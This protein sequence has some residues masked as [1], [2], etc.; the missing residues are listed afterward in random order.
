METTQPLPLLGGLSAAQFMRRYWQ[1]KPLL[2]RQAIPAMVPPI[3]R[4]ALFALAEREDVE[5]RLIRHGKAGWTLRQ[6]PL[7]RRALPPLKQPE[8]TLL[9]QGVDL[10][11]EGVHALLQQFRFL[12]DARLDDLMISYASDRGGVGAHFDSYDVFLLQAQ[13]TRRWSIGRQSD[14]RL[15]EGVPL[16]ILEN[17]EPEQSFVLEPGDMLYL[18]PR[19]AHDGVAVGDD[20]MTCSIGLRS[21]ASG[22]LGADLL[23]RMAQAYS[24]ALE[25]AGPAELARYRDP[26]QPAVDTPAAMP[27]ALQAFARKA[28]EAALRDPDAI[29]RALGESLTEPKA[30]VWFGE[31]TDAPDVLNQVALDRRTRMLYD[32]RHLY[33]NGESFRAGGA[34][35][36]LM[37]RLADRRALGPRE[38]SRAS[39][40]ARALLAEWCEAGWLHAE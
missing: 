14:L 34:D 1:K 18:P 35:A 22:E 37:R 40:G 7:A 26:S 23:A 31:G 15:Q 39:E 2:V 8:W 17:F 4:G 27:A 20:C 24:E 28:V 6:G 38:L 25:D 30:N 12:P 29:D 13:G 16:K 32:A 10:H 36:T 3:E 33:I 5:S 21:S 11:H 19:Y 9:V